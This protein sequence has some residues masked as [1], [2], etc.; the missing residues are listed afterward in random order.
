MRD[1]LAQALG[2]SGDRIGSIRWLDP[3]RMGAARDFFPKRAAN[4]LP[5]LG[6]KVTVRGYWLWRHSTQCALERLRVQATGGYDSRVVTAGGR[7]GR[8]RGNRNVATNRIAATIR[9]ATTS[10]AITPIAPSF[11]S[12]HPTGP[13]LVMSKKRNRRNAAIMPVR[14]TCV[15]PIIAIH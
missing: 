6:R 10:S 1:I 12:A 2:Q 14:L 9:P 8:A 7:Y 13:T 5:I 4:G 3:G 11:R 15:R